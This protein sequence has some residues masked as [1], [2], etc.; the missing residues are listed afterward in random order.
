LGIDNYGAVSTGTKWNA[1]GGHGN[2]RKLPIIYAGYL[3]SDSDML[4]IGTTYPA[5]SNTFS[6]DCQTFYISQSD[7][8]KG[9]GYT[10]SMIGYPEYGIRHCAGL[11]NH[12]DEASW[13]APYRSCCTANAWNGHVLVAHILGFQDEWN[14]DALFDY[15]ERFML[16]QQGQPDPYGIV[17]TQSDVSGSI[18]RSSSRFMENM[19]DT[20]W[21][22]ETCADQG[23]Y[24]CPSGNTCS[25]P[26][27]GTGCGGTCCLNEASCTPESTC[28]DDNCDIGESCITCPQDCGACPIDCIHDADQPICDGCVDTA[29][30]SAYIDL[31]KSGSVG[32]SE[33]MVV[34][35]LWKQGC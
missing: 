22:V 4:S 17:G 8:D 3:L 15:T 21:S 26:R 29:E 5:M 9:I 6:D 16:I 2:G 35:T 28:G 31:W 14:H 24:C 20:Y 1:N 11:S 19:W 18:Y 25:S 10:S 32:M 30:L 12:P 33:L 13:D 23:F 27:S 7:I 34:I